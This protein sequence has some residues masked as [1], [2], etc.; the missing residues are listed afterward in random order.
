M[1]PFDKLHSVDKGKKTDGRLVAPECYLA[2]LHLLTW[3]QIDQDVGGTG[4]LM[5]C[6]C[7]TDTELANFR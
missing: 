2:T 3:L 4:L 1:L 5:A 7:L 6:I